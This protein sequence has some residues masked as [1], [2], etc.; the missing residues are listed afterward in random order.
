[1]GEFVLPPAL[2]RLAD[3]NR[4]NADDVMELRQT[5]FAEGLASVDDAVSV[6]ALDTTCR[7][8]CAEWNQFFREFLSDFIVNK[9]EPAGHLGDKNA[10]WLIS[11][12]SRDGMVATRTE[13]R[14]MIDAM[15]RA[16]TSPAFYSAYLLK[17]VADAVISGKGPLMRGR[18]ARKLVITAEDAELI[19]EIV[20]AN[21]GDK[22]MAV[23]REEA[24]ILFILN[25]RSI[26]AQNAPAWHD[27]FVKALANFLMG[28]SGYGV[29]TRNVALARGEW[30]DSE[31]AGGARATY[32]RFVAESLKT[33]LP[34]YLKTADIQSVYNR[35]SVERIEAE[36]RA[37]L[38]HVSEAE[39]L[40]S[41]I[42]QDGYM[43]QNERAVLAALR[44][45][46]ASM[47]P[48]MEPLLAR[49]A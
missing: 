38:H 7:N 10:R 19:R 40:A 39:W 25:D 21:G 35:R 8:K 2:A 31:V 44:E 16:E 34:K 12:V 22:P 14:M 43:R 1:M 45:E 5:V 17:Q 11:A 18:V 47:P 30:L 27:F 36:K 46:I 24:E 9:T 32:E 49:V 23:T 6:I 4:I 15:K 28:M 26:E 41:R 29:P 33:V 42:G 37:G 20:L 13:L 48:E 3:A